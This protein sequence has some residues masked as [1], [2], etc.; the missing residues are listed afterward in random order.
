MAR[1]RH[2]GPKPKRRKRYGPRK[3]RSTRFFRDG[4]HI[5]AEREWWGR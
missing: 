1:V 2:K 4:K 5:P 3:V